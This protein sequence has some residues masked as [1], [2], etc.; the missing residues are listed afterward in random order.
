[1]AI[2]PESDIYYVQDK[3]NH[4]VRKKEK[5]GKIRLIEKKLNLN[6]YFDPVRRGLEMKKL[7]IA[8][9]NQKNELDELIKNKSVIDDAVIKKD[10]CYYTIVKEPVA[11]QINFYELNEKKIEKAQRLSG[12]FSILT[13]GLDLSAKEVLSSCRLRDEQEK[14]F[15]QMKDQMASDRQRNWSEE[16]KTGRLLILFVSLILG[17]YVRHVWKSTDLYNNFDSSLEMLDEMRSIRCVEYPNRAKMI[18]P[19]I[20]AQ[21]D[22]CKAFGF[23]MP[24]G[25]APTN[26]SRQKQKRKRGRPPIKIVKRG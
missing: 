5:S 20:G 8:I 19:F 4:V 17:S 25:C 21:V 2:D 15:Q 6:I 12:F 24:D 22:I 7:D 26:K 13:H 11:K 3:I 1:M 14:Y 10:F 16:G 9:F 23:D 18:T